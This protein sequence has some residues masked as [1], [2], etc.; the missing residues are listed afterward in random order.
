MKITKYLFTLAAILIL[1]L[2]CAT[3]PESFVRV[4]NYN[5]LRITEKGEESNNISPESN[6]KILPYVLEEDKLDLLA[7]GTVMELENLTID[8]GPLSIVEEVR[9]RGF[10]PT[11]FVYYSNDTKEADTVCIYQEEDLIYYS[12]YA[13]TYSPLQTI[14]LEGQE[15]NEDKELDLKNCS[16]SIDIIPNKILSDESAEYFARADFFHHDSFRRGDEFNDAEILVNGKKMKLEND[17]IFGSK[18]DF[19]LSV[20]DRISVSFKHPL[21]GD[22]NYELTVPPIMKE[23]S[24]EP[25]MTM[26]IPNE[27]DNY[28]LRWEPQDCDQYNVRAYKANEE[29][30]LDSFGRSVT[31]TF[32]QW[33]P[34]ELQDEGEPVPYIEFVVKTSNAIKLDMFNDWSYI[35]VSAPTGA[36]YGNI[37]MEDL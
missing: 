10:S 26:G 33:D 29:E 9:D 13:Y 25:T 20:G 17:G 34:W 8:G 12:R 15:A 27:T 11:L 21:V 35:E 19:V 24:V 5:T 22:L 7:G 18:K 32:H 31:S 6:K 3:E 28:L 36:R 37:R 16:F 23:V 30:R 14:V 2:S 1:F 4:E